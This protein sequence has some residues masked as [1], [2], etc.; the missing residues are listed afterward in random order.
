MLGGT[1]AVPLSRGQDLSLPARQAGRTV[2]ILGGLCL[3]LLVVCVIALGLG[4]EY[5]P[6]GAIVGMA[7]QWLP[8]H[9][10]RTWSDTDLTIIT[11]I[12]MPR[13][14]TA[15]FVGGALSVA[16]AAFQALF[17]NPLADPGIVGTS[18]GASLGAVVALVVPVQI[19]WLGFSFV[20]LAA[21]IGALAT[22]LLVY[23]LARVGSYVPSTTLLLAGFA[24]SAAFN[25]AAA[26]IEA[27]SDRLRDMYI[28]LLGNLDQS[29]AQ[30]LLVVAPLLAIGVVGLLV[31]AGDLN[32]LLLGDEQSRYLGLDVTQRRLLI[33][34]LG[35]LL[36]S[37][38]VALAGL[39][40]FVGLLV[41]HIAR[42]LFGA[43][44]R[45]LLPASLVL[46]ATF[47]VSVD[48]VARTVAAPQE[49]PVGLITALLGAPWFLVLLRR[50]RGDYTF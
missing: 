44:H 50:K 26:V 8:I 25:A 15:V 20:S 19:A 37:V 2:L 30:Q 9:P 39:I 18:A 27:L 34:V 49:L 5:I 4:E 38:A 23:A 14:L 42:L 40:A 48:T 16:G 35:S 10:A 31:L 28:W 6:P 17:R 47:L 36:T 46:G 1:R 22:M 13:I 43:N 7:L 32:V 21:F 12:R 3:A 45:L 24:V 33:L 41:P 11:L 29:T